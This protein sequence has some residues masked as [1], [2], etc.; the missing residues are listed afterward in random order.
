MADGIRI[1]TETID[2]LAGGE[3]LCDVYHP[4]QATANGAASILL[5]GG[6]WRFGDRTMMADA[7]TALAGHGFLAVAL[8]YRLIG[9]AAWPAP[10]ADTKAAVR[11]LRAEA[12]RFGVDPELITLTGFSAGAHLALLA[13]GTPAGG[14]VPDDGVYREVSERA[15]AVA[16]FFPPTRLG[17]GQAQ[18]LGIAPEEA[19]ML[20]PIEHVTAAF[21][22]TLL[23][24]GTGDTMVP[25]AASVEMFEALVTA[26][27]SADLR[28]YAGLPHEFQQ[29]PG[30]LAPTIADVAA[31][32]DRHAANRALFDEAR[33]ALQRRWEE[34]A[35]AARPAAAR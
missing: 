22:P 2:A 8:E 5:H 27:A 35:Q 3:L 1:E 17:A 7:A 18:M 19:R 11:W 10:L 12:S 24:H 21:P 29:L 26:G 23:L 33:D 28:L 4:D 25:H 15:A 30:L 6:G 14:E 32:F 34:R 31:F 20:S 16:A 13:A 9:P